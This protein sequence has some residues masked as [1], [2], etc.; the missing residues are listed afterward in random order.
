[1]FR[2]EEIPKL[3]VAALLGGVVSATLVVALMPAEPVGPQ[4]VRAAEFRSNAVPATARVV[5]VSEQVRKLAAR[6]EDLER[7]LASKRVATSDGGSTL[8]ADVSWKLADLDRRLRTLRKQLS[9]VRFEPEGKTPEAILESLGRI[10]VKKTRDGFAQALA[11]IPLRTRFLELFAHHEGAPN[12][13]RELARDYARVGQPRKAIAAI[14]RFGPKTTLLPWQ[15][16]QLRLVSEVR[17][18]ERVTIAQRLAQ[19]APDAWTRANAMFTWAQTLQWLGRRERA[20]DV[21]QA[22]LSKFAQVQDPNVHK[23]VLKRA[24][25]SL[26]ALRAGR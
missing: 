19:T 3:V 4:Q 14:D 20:A 1:M 13:L 6:V 17:N 15:L 7:A 25:S 11:R 16:D 10:Y 22:L 23:Y 26:E 24:R 21:F 12:Q 5:D 18:A 8:P 2:G 9:Q